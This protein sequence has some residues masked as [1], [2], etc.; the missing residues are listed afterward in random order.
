MNVNGQV[1]GP[2]DDDDDKAV[3]QGGKEDNEDD[4]NVAINSPDVLADV[5]LVKTVSQYMQAI[6]FLV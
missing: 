4:D 3:A 1:H 2:Y 6:R 5:Q